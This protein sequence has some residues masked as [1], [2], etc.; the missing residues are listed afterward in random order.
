MATK[1]AQSKK[2]EKIEIEDNLR[3][4]FIRFAL[5]YCAN[6]IILLSLKYQAGLGDTLI[7]TVIIII[8]S[9][10]FTTMKFIMDK[11]RLFTQTEKMKLIWVSWGLFWFISI[12][13]TTLL[14]FAFAGKEAL[15]TLVSS[16]SSMP[17]LQFITTIAAA[18]A[19]SFALLYVTYGFNAKREFEALKK[20]GKI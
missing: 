13:A 11:K 14:T 15:D 1:K 8:L 16:F 4:Y 19:V 6:I 18:S 20:Q 7:F 2:Q 3:S 10:R 5:I 9:A 12:I 17:S